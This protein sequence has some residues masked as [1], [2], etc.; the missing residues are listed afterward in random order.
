MN[1]KSVGRVGGQNTSTY[2][3]H[4]R[5]EGM[6]WN[7]P[8]MYAEA[9]LVH[10]KQVSQYRKEVA[11]VHTRYEKAKVDDRTQLCQYVSW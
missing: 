10:C 7:V 2:F 1:S 3:G 11:E 4:E 5:H 9:K 6:V 8:L